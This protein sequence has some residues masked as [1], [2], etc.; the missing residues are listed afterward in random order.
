M[1]W[2]AWTKRF[3]SLAA[4]VLTAGAAMA[5]SWTPEPA[6]P[7]IPNNPYSP[8]PCTGTV[9]TD[10]TCS[11]NFDAWIEQFAA[12]QITG[13]CGGG[14][15]CPTANVT[16]AQM[17][18]F[19][20][21]AMRG[22][23]SWSPGDRG[24][25]DTALGD[26]ALLNNTT[27]ASNTGVGYRALETQSFDNGGVAWDSDNTAVGA[28]ALRFNQPSNNSNGIRNTAVGA[29]ALG[30]NV[31]GYSNTAVGVG[32]LIFLLNAWDNTAV[33]DHAGARNDMITGYTGSPVQLVANQ[34][35]N[36]DTFISMSGATAQVDNCTA[37]GMD[38]YCDASNQVRL[39]NVF[40]TSIGG[41]VAWSA[42]SDARAKSEIN[43]LDLGLPF[44]LAL[45]PVSY[46]Y[47]SGN[48]RIDMGFVGQDIEALLGDRYNVLDVGGDAERTLSLR[49][50]E[51]IA[52]LVKAVQE[53]QE[54]IE[55][56]KR[57]IEA[58]ESKLDEID[59]LRAQVG[60]LHGRPEPAARLSEP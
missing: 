30:N 2:Q 25:S 6:T 28:S 26:S 5:Q 49:Y 32:S 48:G 27:A 23:S 52:P 45:R 60:A 4:A 17:A 47:K 34:S 8:P 13:G 40:V 21:K 42:L 31:T 39:G 37:V 53:Q 10:V 57:Q 56:Q 15:Y 54:E 33:G 43:D 18:V 1:S 46:R 44:V 59:D 20:E 16:R 19:V 14:A 55:T 58:L 24:N 38:G 50:S 29:V 36:Y 12:D 11:T 7:Q 51:L 9:F 41:K 3:S 22:T 35:G